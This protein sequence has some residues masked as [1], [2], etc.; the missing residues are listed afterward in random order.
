[1]IK[2]ELG[3]RMRIV[4]EYLLDGLQEEELGVFYMPTKGRHTRRS[5]TLSGHTWRSFL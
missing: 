3:R 1:M 5:T 4:L 2:G